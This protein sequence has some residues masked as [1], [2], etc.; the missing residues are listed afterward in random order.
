MLLLLCQCC[1]AAAAPAK[2]IES[3]ASL[4][5]FRRTTKTNKPDPGPDVGLAPEEVAAAAAAA[6]RARAAQGASGSAPGSAAPGAAAAPPRPTPRRPPSRPPSSCSGGAAPLPPG[7]L[8]LSTLRGGPAVAWEPPVYGVDIRKEEHTAVTSDGWTL[9]I[10]HTTD[11][12]AP[13]PPKPRRHPVLLCPGLASSGVG[14][15]DLMPEVSIADYLA[16]KGWD[17]WCAC[18]RGN[19]AS[20]K[21]SKIDVSSWTI[22]GWRRFGG[23]GVWEGGWGRGLALILAA[24]SCAL[25]SCLGALHTHHHHHTTITATT[26]LYPR[27]INTITPPP[28]SSHQQT[29]T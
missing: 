22:G 21:E 12:G 23:L 2:L 17:V 15:F 1:A 14:T 6:A 7:A 3:L 24:W 26:P 19:G 11:A 27:L 16:A 8:N 4:S 18:L 9:H 20:D 5:P 13:A 10:V 25:A 29:T 28:P